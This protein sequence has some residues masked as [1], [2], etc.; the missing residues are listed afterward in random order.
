MNH[1]LA[2][3]R[4][5]HPDS[6]SPAES[7]LCRAFASRAP[8]RQILACPLSSGR[9]TAAA[10]DRSRCRRCCLCHRSAWVAYPRARPCRPPAGTARRAPICRVLACSDA[11]S[12][13]RFRSA[14]AR[15]SSVVRV[16]APAHRE[17]DPAVSARFRSRLDAARPAPSSRP[18]RTRAARSAE[19][20]DPRCAPT[21]AS[22]S[23]SWP[24]AR[25]RVRT[26][27]PAGA[28]ATNGALI[29]RSPL[30]RPPRGQPSPPTSAVSRPA[31][32]GRPAGHAGESART[33][34][35]GP[36]RARRQRQP[37][38]AGSWLPSPPERVASPP[39]T[40]DMPSVG[41]GPATTPIRSSSRS[42]H[43][44]RT[45]V[46]SLTLI[47]RPAHSMPLWWRSRAYGQ[48]GLS[49]SGAIGPSGK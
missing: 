11:R 10:R 14:S 47:T 33:A 19:A 24:D 34:R 40:S 46:R 12:A 21:A 6:V 26:L 44:I 13:S 27:A 16:I 23:P 35:A 3:Q 31:G 9:S 36:E 4:A 15:R 41:A 1:R 42:Q 49:V 32:P 30:T 48:P 2:S 38:P 7:R 22:T 20:S 8:P 25:S 45:G 29:A 5:R 39:G 37:A 43:I 18:S 28:A 17:L